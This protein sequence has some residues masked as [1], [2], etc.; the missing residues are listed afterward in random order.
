MHTNRQQGIRKIVPGGPVSAAGI[1]VTEVTPRVTE[2]VP[3]LL[4]DLLPVSIRSVRRFTYQKDAHVLTHARYG[5]VLR[6]LQEDTL[7]FNHG[8]WQ[9]TTGT[10][11]DAEAEAVEYVNSLVEFAFKY[12]DVD[13]DD[14]DELSGY[15]RHRYQSLNDTLTTISTGRGPVNAGLEALAKGPVRLHEELDDTTQPITLVLDGESWKKP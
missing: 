11:S 8:T 14:L 12:Y 9:N 7:G 5:S 6:H 10:W 15:H 4:T 3:E 1:T 2:W 13:E